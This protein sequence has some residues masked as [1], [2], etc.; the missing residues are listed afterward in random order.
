M[1]KIKDLFD[2]SGKIAI[3]TGGLGHLGFAMTETLLELGSNV[4]VTV[5]EKEMNDEKVLSKLDRLNKDYPKQDILIRPIDFF[6]EESLKIFFEEIKNKFKTIDILINNAYYGVQKPIEEMN[7][8]EFNKS[9]E[10][11][12]SSVFKCSSLAMPLMKKNKGGVII[13]IASMYGVVSPDWRI[14]KDTKFNS[15][16][17]YGPSKAAIIQ[18]TKYLASYWARYGIRVNSI[19]PGPFPRE[20][21]VKDKLFYKNLK[22]KTMLNRIGTPED[23]KGVIALLSSN[24]SGYI[25]GQNFIIDGG[26][27]SW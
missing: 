9:V 12:F 27:T 10:G 15:P 3:I 2:L 1:K 20:E 24:A 25:T 13:N 5:T 4:I 7:F 19:S 21:V 17:S 16:A 14:Y 8:E 26:W 22:E 6:N 11:T 23:L 18:V